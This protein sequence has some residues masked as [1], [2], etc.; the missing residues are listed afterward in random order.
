MSVKIRI[1]K[2]NKYKD[3]N[4]MAVS[5]QDF[6][7]KVYDQMQ[8]IL[9]N[10]A[11]LRYYSNNSY[12]TY[13]RDINHWKSELSAQINKIVS[14][15]LKNNSKDKRI[16][17]IYDI[18]EKYP[19]FSDVETIKKILA[20]KFVVENILK[21]TDKEDY[22]DEYIEVCEDWVYELDILKNIL[23]KNDTNIVKSY[24]SSLYIEKDNSID[25]DIKNRYI[26]ILSYY[27][28]IQSFIIDKNVYFIQNLI[29]LSA[30][31]FWALYE[32][33]YSEDCSIDIIVDSINYFNSNISDDEIINN[34]YS[35]LKNNAFDI[36]K[37]INHE[38]IKE[39]MQ[40][41]LNNLKELK[42]EIIH[43]LKDTDDSYLLNFMYN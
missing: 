7:E 2:E 4:E 10:W 28:V 20:K 37:T 31:E 21:S 1:F 39:A 11:L 17:A 32:Y 18:F 12:K 24:V 35:L 25:Y 15:D 40:L 34:I 36:Y 30:I 27:I 19:Q 13:S 38:H 9:E 43:S 33:T 8:Q 29:D 22:T 16:K 3:L 14:I 6:I 23:Y 41:C 42:N 26:N 5:R